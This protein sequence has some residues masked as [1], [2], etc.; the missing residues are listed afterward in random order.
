[1]GA[2]IEILHRRYPLCLR[3]VAP[4]MGA[5]IEIRIMSKRQTRYFVAPRM[6]AWIEITSQNPYAFL[7]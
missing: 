5:W 1:M 4:R 7:Y 2:W 3:W 6:G